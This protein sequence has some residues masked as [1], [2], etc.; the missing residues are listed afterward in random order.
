MNQFAIRDPF[1]RCFDQLYQAQCSH[2]QA[3]LLP[4]E[5]LRYRQNCVKKNN[6]SNI[7]VTLLG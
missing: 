2:S 3:Q 6:A 1:F 7:P 4:L 5:L